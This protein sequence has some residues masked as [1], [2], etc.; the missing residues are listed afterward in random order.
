MQQRALLITLAQTAYNK[1]DSAEHQ[2][3]AI[4]RRCLHTHPCSGEM[5]SA[6]VT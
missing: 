1:N 4:E 2:T 5:A 6:C 3:T